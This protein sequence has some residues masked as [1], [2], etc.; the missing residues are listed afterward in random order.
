MMCLNYIH[1]SSNNLG[2]RT[3]LLTYRVSDLVLFLIFFLLAFQNAFQKLFGG[4][5]SY[6][7]EVS[8]LILCCWAVFSMHGQK[9]S[10]S[11]I[12]CLLLLSNS[13]F[14]LLGL[15]GNL[16]YKLQPAYQAIAIDAFAC[17]KF[18]I[19]LVSSVVILQKRSVIKVASSFAK[20]VLPLLLI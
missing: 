1:N 15:C 9:T 14:L 16:S 5:F 6:I 12:S 7:D 3:S 19:S 11:K 10:Y 4:F 8:A 20:F 17:A 18:I 13:L 2:R